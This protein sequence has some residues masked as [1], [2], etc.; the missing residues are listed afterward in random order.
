LSESA[1][2]AIGLAVLGCVCVGVLGWMRGTSVLLAREEALGTNSAV[3][4]SMIVVLACALAPL[5]DSGAPAM[6]AAPIS[7]IEWPTRWEGREL[8]PMALSAVERRF[9]ERFPGH[10]ARFRF[11]GGELVLREVREP[12]RLLHPAADCYRGAGFEVGA[13]RLERRDAERGLW[14]CFT[15]HRDGRAMRVC[16]RIVDAGGADFTDTSAWYWAALLGRSDGPW[17]AV[18]QATPQ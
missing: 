5:I 14:R 18:T 12:T 9:A 1:H 11:D 15:A 4:V 10:I 8:R 2:E 3:R 17:L 16:E 7:A 13:V 6:A